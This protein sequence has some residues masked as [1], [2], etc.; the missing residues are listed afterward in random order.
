M[1]MPPEQRSIALFTMS[2]S[3]APVAGWSATSLGTNKEQVK[4]KGAA[5]GPIEG[6]Q[7][8]D[9]GDWETCAQSRENPQGIC[10]I[11]CAR[12]DSNALETPRAP[13]RA[14]A[15]SR[16]SRTIPLNTAGSGLRCTPQAGQTSPIPIAASASLR[17][18]MVWCPPISNDEPPDRLALGTKDSNTRGR[19]LPAA[20]AR[21]PDPQGLQILAGP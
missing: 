17:R 7:R 18:F 21:A 1:Q 10:R 14:R 19:C 4:W 15:H 20:A 5:C 12:R 11:P 8:P 9:A 3:T 13:E 6:L 16:R 2:N